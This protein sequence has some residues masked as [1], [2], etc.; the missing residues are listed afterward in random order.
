MD[1]DQ[2]VVRVPFDG[3]F[4]ITTYFGAD[5]YPSELRHFGSHWGIDYGLPLRT[6][7]KACA[8]GIVSRV[9][10][11]HATR[12][13]WL[14]IM[15]ENSFSSRYLHN[16]QIL[17]TEGAIVSKGDVISLS[18]STGLSTGPHLHWELLRDNDT[19]RVNP[20]NFIGNYI[21]YP[22][23]SVA[24]QEPLPQPGPLTGIPES[25]SEFR[26]EE[27]YLVQPGDNLGQIIAKR[28]NLVVNWAEYS[29]KQGRFY[30][31]YQMNVNAN[32]GK[33]PL[34]PNSLIRL[35]S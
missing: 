28:F 11:N 14:E 10:L 24:A 33:F 2:H 22:I 17:V 13:N 30:E 27:Y 25:S 4:P 29:A 32:P 26:T 31:L 15:H 16:D 19:V 18:G 21:G 6:P 7:V 3:D 34:Q 35:V 8:H 23:A 20:L 9:E 5:A 1:Y 12:G